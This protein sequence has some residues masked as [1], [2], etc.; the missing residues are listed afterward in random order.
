VPTALL[1]DRL[2]E[3][4]SLS[5]LEAQAF[6]RV[7]QGNL[8]RGRELAASSAA[9]E[10]RAR[11]LEWAR[12]VSS[13]NLYAIE[14][15]VDD[16]LFSVEVRAEER[17]KRLDATRKRDL[18]WSGDAR[19]KARVE[20]LYDQ[21]VKRERRRA[22]ADGLAEALTA[23]SSWYRDLA[24]VAVGSEEAALNHDYLLELRNEAFAGLLPGYLG[25][26]EAVN[27]AEERFRYNVDAR[28]VLTDMLLSIKEALT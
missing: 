2:R 11:L 3:E 26:V 12:Q 7:A 13:S 10:Q 16:L 24:V 21:K 4:H 9:R 17:V 15:M 22:V 27:R 14:I 18:E 19:T 8:E 25:A 6:A 20:K 28:S 5:E 1:A 23:F